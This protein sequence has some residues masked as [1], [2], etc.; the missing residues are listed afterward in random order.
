[1]TNFPSVRH[2]TFALR[3][4]FRL[5]P[6]GMAGFVLVHF[7]FLVKSEAARAIRFL[8]IRRRIACGNADGPRPVGAPYCANAQ[9]YIFA[10]KNE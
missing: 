3:N 7:W 8:G 10:F 9:L 4:S 5:A 2:S 6:H 1:M